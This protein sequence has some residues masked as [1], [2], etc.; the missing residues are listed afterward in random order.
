VFDDARLAEIGVEPPS[1][2]R[3]ARALGAAGMDASVVGETLA[4]SAA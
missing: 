4:G 2:A 3:L 1:R